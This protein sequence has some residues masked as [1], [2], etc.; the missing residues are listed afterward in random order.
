MEAT[1]LLILAVAG[2]LGALLSLGGTPLA[3]RAALAT[4]FVDK[5]STALKT[6]ASATPY[7]GGMAVF[8]P[9]LT[10]AALIFELDAGFL[11]VLLAATLAAM[12]G[13]MDDFGAMRAG[14][15]MVGQ[16]VII[17]VLLR[18]GVRIDLE[19]LPTWL[20]LALTAFWL[21]SIKNALNFLDIMD[22]LAA[23]VSV[24]ATA[25]FLA[26]ALLQGDAQMAAMAAALLGALAGYLRYSLPRARI[27]LGDS[28]SLFLGVILGS[29]A[30]D[31]DYSGVSAWAVTTPLLILAVPCFEIAFTVLCRVFSGKKPWLGSPDHVALRLKRLGLDVPRVLV[32]AASGGLVGGGLGLWMLR[33]GPGVAPWCLGLAGLLALA[34]TVVLARAPKHA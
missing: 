28:G 9:F 3:I 21:L 22:G 1:N 5:P 17:L 11:G 27:F 29:L 31:L 34:L 24:I 4:G 13:L 32:V 23:T 18:A 25:F 30:L 8:V 33:G 6:H 7:L 20:N 16:L 19:F 26:V 12:L 10:V 2:V 14:V 15:K